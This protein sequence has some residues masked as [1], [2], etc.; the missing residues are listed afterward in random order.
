MGNLSSSPPSDPQRATVYLVP[1]N[2]LTRI[3]MT[4]DDV[5]KSAW[6]TAQ[7]RRDRHLL[8]TLATWLA[9]TEF[10]G[11]S[12]HPFGNPRVVIDIEVADGTMASYYANRNQLHEVA[13][14]RTR[15]IDQTTFGNH[16]ASLLFFDHAG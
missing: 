4:A 13:S 10:Q 12:P 14:G 8:T 15:G 7:V 16:L 2:F 1:W 11:P 6:V 3:P 9:V 5:R